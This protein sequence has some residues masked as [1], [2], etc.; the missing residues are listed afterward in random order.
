MGIFSA[1][2][3]A[4]GDEAQSQYSGS[5]KTG[6]NDVRLSEITTKTGEKNGKKWESLIF[7]FVDNDNSSTQARFFVPLE[8]RDTVRYT[9]DDKNG[10][11]FEIPS[12]AEEL[13]FAVRHII[14]ALNPQAGIDYD[15]NPKDF[16]SFDEFLNYWKE[17]AFNK[18]IE[19]KKMTQIKI[20]PEKDNLKYYGIPK[21]WLSIPKDSSGEVKKG[22]RPYVYNN[23]LG[24]PL[25]LNKNEK[26]LIEQAKNTPDTIE[27]ASS[28]VKE[29]TVNNSVVANED[30]MTAK[31]PTQSS[32][33]DDLP[34]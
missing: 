23:W 34:F 5:L 20:I 30:K 6:I 27:S 11:Y 16:D 33:I 10:K 2:N 21:N 3:M 28:M 31:I 25:F 7:T 22:A 12:T 32:D 9:G 18:A 17:K 29:D 24:N 14:D 4:K 15:Q 1:A 8:E 13:M 19:D 26:D